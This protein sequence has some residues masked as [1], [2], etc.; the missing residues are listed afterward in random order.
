MF[1]E[2]FVSMN[3]DD[4]RK[5]MIGRQQTLFKETFIILRF[6]SVFE[7]KKKLMNGEK[8]NKTNKCIAKMYEMLR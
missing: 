1:N 2:A 6:I 5:L 8:Q 7:R 4:A 3:S